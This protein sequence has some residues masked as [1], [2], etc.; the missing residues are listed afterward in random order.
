MTR[1]SQCDGARSVLSC[2]F[3]CK[4]HREGCPDLSKCAVG[5]Y[6]RSTGIVTHNFGRCGGLE[7]AISYS[8][9]VFV[10]T[11]GTVGIVSEKVRFN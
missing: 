1:I 2:F 11:D 8:A 3:D 7:S 5:I 4:V 6:Y 10:E 9:G